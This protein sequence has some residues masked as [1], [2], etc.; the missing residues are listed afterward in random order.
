[1][2]KK[3]FVHT[4]LHFVTCN[5]R[6]K[7]FL[8]LDV[9]F[10]KKKWLGWFTRGVKGE[11]QNG[12]TFR[13]SF[14]GSQ[15]YCLIKLLFF[16]TYFFLYIFSNKMRFFFLNEIDA[17]LYFWLQRAPILGFERGILTQ[18]YNY[19][20]LEKM[21]ELSLTLFFSFL[22]LHIFDSGNLFLLMIATIYDSF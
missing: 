9:F 18:T 21:V 3:Y 20:R 10:N 12:Q 4:I 22:K 19:Q 17:Q 1:M 8:T 6:T 16:L 11:P 13:Y 5:S 14:L 2:F 15:N 7:L